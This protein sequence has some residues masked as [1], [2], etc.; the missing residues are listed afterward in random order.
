MICNLSKMLKNYYQEIFKKKKPEMRK[1]S[2]QGL[3]IQA[4]DCLCVLC[5]LLFV[6][7]FASFVFLFICMISWL[8]F[9]ERI[10]ILWLSIGNLEPLR[11]KLL[12]K[13]FVEKLFKLNPKIPLTHS[14]TWPRSTHFKKNM[15]RKEVTNL[16]LHFGSGDTLQNAPAMDPA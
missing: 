2:P 5:F 13:M 10:N 3:N 11:R 9:K 8:A 16:L 4:I 15:L 6:L 12:H 7:A 14:H 1:C